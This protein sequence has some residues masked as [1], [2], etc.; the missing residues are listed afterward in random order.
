MSEEKIKPEC[1]L[2]GE[3]GNIFNLLSIASNTLKQN[4]MDQE[5]KKMYERVYACGSYEEALMIIGDY[6]TIC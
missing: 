6:V 2:I 4:G 5:S 1:N 3:D